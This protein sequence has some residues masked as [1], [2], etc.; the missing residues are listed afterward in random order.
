M[1]PSYGGALV[2]IILNDDALKTQW[3]QEVASMRERM[4]SLRGLLVDKLHAAGVDQDFSFV[5]QQ[6]GMFSYLCISP[7]Q[8]RAARASHA[9]YFVDSSR[10]NI[11]GISQNNVDYLAQGLHSVLK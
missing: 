2:D 10:V 8:V 7:E 9:I 4:T 11:A 6:K 5:K 1:P 3:Q